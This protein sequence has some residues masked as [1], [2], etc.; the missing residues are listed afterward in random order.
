MMENIK[1]VF[2]DLDDT[3]WWFSENTKVAIRFVYDK[4]GLSRWCDYDTYLK[5]YCDKNNELWELYHYGKISKDFLVSERFDYVLRSIGY[6][7]NKEV[8]G[9]CLNED[10]LDCLARQ[11]KILPGAKELLEYLGGKYDVNV[12][13]N[14]FRGFQ[15]RKLE[16]GGI[17]HLVHR[18]ILSDDCGVTKPL[19]GIY[20]YALRECG[21]EAESTV[22]IGDNYDADIRGAHKARWR[23]IFFDW[24]GME[25]PQPSIADVTVRSLLEIVERRIL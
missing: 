14:G 17:A 9:A 19:P 20:E 13:S 12:L 11:K 4:Y 24:R 21:A 6:N 10:Y 18:L 5:L 1:T 22:M 16:S 25:V 3:L 2:I 8:M 15:P 23:T 7:G